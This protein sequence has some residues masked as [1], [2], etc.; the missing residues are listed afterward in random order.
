[1]VLGQ[2]IEKQVAVGES[3]ESVVVGKK[4][5]ALSRIDVINGKSDV[6]CQLRQQLHF[7]FMEE[8][9]LP[10]VESEDTCDLIRHDQRQHDHRTAAEFAVLLAERNARIVLGIV[11]DR[12]R[13][14]S[15][16]LYYHGVD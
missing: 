6:T 13:F 14:G 9:L 15:D 5:E 3:G 7:F 12:R 16:G 2:T 11:R 10:G 8:L 4:V 1:H